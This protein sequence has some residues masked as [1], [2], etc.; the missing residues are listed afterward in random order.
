MAYNHFF[1]NFSKDPYYQRQGFSQT[2]LKSTLSTQ[3]T[4]FLVT[5]MVTGP[6]YKYI[7]E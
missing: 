3:F 2:Y 1:W 5:F 6:A 7:F 4:L